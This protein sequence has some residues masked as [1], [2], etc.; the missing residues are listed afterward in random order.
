MERRFLAAKPDLVSHRHH[1]STFQGGPPPQRRPEAC[2]CA[3]WRCF[4]I[5]ARRQAARAAIGCWDLRLR[6]RVFSSSEERGSEPSKQTELCLF[7]W[8]TMTCWSSPWEPRA[9]RT[10]RGRKIPKRAGL[11]FRPASTSTRSRRKRNRGSGKPTATKHGRSMIC[12]T[13]PRLHPSF[14]NI[15]GPEM[16]VHELVDE[17]RDAVWRV[18]HHFIA[19]F[20]DGHPGSARRIS[21][22]ST[23][24]LSPLRCRKSSLRP[25]G[26]ARAP[27]HHRDRGR[28]VRHRHRELE[29]RLRRRG[30]R[31][32]DPP[33][34]PAARFL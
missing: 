14:T 33:S 24:P 25:G 20:I 4:C 6:E 10:S 3:T 12:P 21:G 31:T 16:A 18:A 29:R 13:S 8:A 5:R 2:R 22:N 34:S 27:P 17:K 32:G 15:A 19:W 7:A 30:P 11:G 26:V 23:R 1:R 28:P 9:A